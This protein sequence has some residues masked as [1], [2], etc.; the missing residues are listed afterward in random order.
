MQVI[1]LLVHSGWLGWLARIQSFQR[2]EGH[3][4]H[5]CEFPHANGAGETALKVE[6]AGEEGEDL[7]LAVFLVHH[8]T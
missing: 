2:V 8:I 5:E 7:M 1:Q 6:V 4:S 3:W